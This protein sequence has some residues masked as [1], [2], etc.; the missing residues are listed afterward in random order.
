MSWLTSKEASST[1][2]GPGGQLRVLGNNLLVRLH[3]RPKQTPGGI[4]VPDTAIDS[5]LATGTVVAVGRLTGARAPANTPVPGITTG[6]NVLF[7]RF[8][9]RSDSN[10]QLKRLVEDNILR[11]RPD[12]VLLVL[13]D[14][15]VKRVQ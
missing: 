12:D 9:D 6:D 13:D 15:D 14:D 8:L 7:V 2:K 5:M 4:V 11:I 10:P 1:Y 3:D